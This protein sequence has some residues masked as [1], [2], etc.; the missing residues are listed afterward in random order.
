MSLIKCKECGAS[1]SDTAKN[2][3]SCGTKIKQPISRWT[4]LVIGLLVIGF[5]ISVSQDEVKK[6][7]LTPEQIK[8]NA[9]KEAEFQ[10]SVAMVRALKASM[11]NPAS[12]TLVNAIKMTDKTLC[13]EYRA[14]NAFNAVIT[15]YK[16]INEA[17]KFVDWNARCG[18]KTGESMSHIRFAM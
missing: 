16:A 6:A 8:E 14:T 3:P 11:N 7:E 9:E 4:I 12:F 15:E 2:C 17:G 1:V 13:V 10:K 5:G 18:G